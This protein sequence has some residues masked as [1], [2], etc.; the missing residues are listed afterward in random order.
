M[1]G[2]CV[3]RKSH[4]L[5][6]L[7]GDLY[8]NKLKRGLDGVLEDGAQLLTETGTPKQLTQQSRQ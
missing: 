1:S 5:N 4:V 3:G 2:R 7:D 8:R 6:C